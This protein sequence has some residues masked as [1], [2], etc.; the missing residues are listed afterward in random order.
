MQGLRTGARRDPRRLPRPHA[1]RARRHRQPGQARAVRAAARA[2]RVRRATATSTRCGPRSTDRTAAVILEPVQGEGGVVLP[3]PG[4]PRRGA[5]DHERRRRAPR[6]RRGAVRHR[7]HRRVAHDA[8]PRAS[9]PT[10]SPWRRASARGL[11]DRGR[12]SRPARPPTSARPGDH[13]STFGGNPVSCAA[14][15]AVLDTIEADGPPRARAAVS[16]RGGP[17]SFDAVD[18]PLLA[19]APGR[20]P[21]ARARAL[22]RRSPARSRPQRARPASSS[23]PC[24][25][26]RS[27]WRR[28][29]CSP[30]SEADAFAARC[31]RARS[32]AAG[33]VTAPEHEGRAARAHRRPAR[34]QRGAQP[35]RGSPSCSRPRARGHAGDAVARPRR[36]RRGQGRAPRRHARSTPFP[37]RAATRARRSS[38]GRGAAVRGS[39]G[40]PARCSSSADSSANIVVLR[41]PPGAAQY[42]ASAI[43]HAVLPDGHRH[44]GRRRHRA[45]R[46]PRPRRR[47][48]RRRCD[49]EPRRERALT[50]MHPRTHDHTGRGTTVTDRV[51]LAY[52][53]GLD[54]SVAIG[55]IAEETGAEVIAVAVDVG[56]GGEDLEV[57]RER[58]LACGA[59]EAEV[60]DA[61][62]EF[63]ERVLPAGAQGQRAL[64]GPLPA[65][66]GA[67][68]PGD[69]QAPRRPRR[70][71]TA[72]PSSPTAAPARATTR[73]GSRSASAT[74]LPT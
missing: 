51:V 48:R 63:A 60:A 45:A 27:G 34:A 54:T 55:W 19:G 42:L 61:R 71:S 39:R 36:A 5:R 11:P 6:R 37:A 7:P 50:A 22:A 10:S 13:G 73:C 3:P 16:A 74:S 70:T 1:G 35:G 56:Q 4:L 23:T 20:G 9:S 24:A 40:W 47:C 28:R 62:D 21:L 44:R 53:G 66:L 41:T 72:R 52:S 38:R 8:P 18:H 25:P 32:L 26:T 65:G 14:A 12:A 2:G 64:H 58:A 30:T 57:I 59:V 29:W 31:L 17:A 68:A 43:D 33:R 67:L 15:L 69:R 46:H 49:A